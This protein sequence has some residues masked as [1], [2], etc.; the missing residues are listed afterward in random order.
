MSRGVEVV[1]R[2]A[3]RYGLAVLALLVV[4]IV[5]RCPTLRAAAVINAGDAVLARA[6]QVVETPQRQAGAHRAQDLL[7][8][9]DRVESVSRYHDR[10][11]LARWAAGD[12][13]GLRREWSASGRLRELVTLFFYDQA[14]VCYSRY[15]DAECAE[16]LYRLTVTLDPTFSEAYLRLA[17]LHQEAEEWE[18]VVWA[19]REGLEGDASQGVQ[20]E[21]H[22][23]LGAAYEAQGA[24][25][26]AAQEFEAAVN[27]DRDDFLAHLSLAWLYLEWG[28][29]E[30][31]L[32]H[33]LRSVLV[34]PSSPVAHVR[35]GD[36]YEALDVGGLARAQYC[37]A[38]Q[39]DPLH[40]GAGA[41]LGTPNSAEPVCP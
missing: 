37:Q 9:A 40:P 33:A 15:G 22:R 26:L 19:C 16:R 38:L 13:E 11:G 29:L 6:L 14:A 24:P 34:R 23:R 1:A 25:D 2:D 7:Q 41:R 4:A 27:L 8:L 20:A 28:E 32:E 17:R 30:A 36:V 31:A 39:L 18:T 5:V 35:L 21:L 12:L 3:M 10:L